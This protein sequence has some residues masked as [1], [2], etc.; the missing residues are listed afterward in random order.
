[1]LIQAASTRVCFCCQT[2]ITSICAC[3]W[4]KQALLVDVFWHVQLP[5]RIRLHC[6]PF[7]GCWLKRSRSLP[8]QFLKRFYPL[9]NQND[10]K[11]KVQVEKYWNFLCWKRRDWMTDRCLSQSQLL[12]IWQMSLSHVFTEAPYLHQK[13]RFNEFWYHRSQKHTGENKHCVFLTV[14]CF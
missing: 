2:L 7:H 14:S 12:S 3:Q 8:H 10:G 13:T 11:K 4:Q 1:M 9:V 5:P 6:S